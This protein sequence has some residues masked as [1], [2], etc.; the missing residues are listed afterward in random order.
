MA[1]PASHPPSTIHRRYTATTTLLCAAQGTLTLEF[2]P[3]TAVQPHVSSLPPSQRLFQS[4]AAPFSI[5]SV[6][7]V[8]VVGDL[9]WDGVYSSALLLDRD[10]AR[11]LTDCPASK[12]AG[13]A[14]SCD[15]VPKLRRPHWRKS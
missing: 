6:G 4:L 14:H 11:F 5:K 13:V 9:H 15:R 3:P 10:K 8:M 7:A 2:N 12:G 1:Q